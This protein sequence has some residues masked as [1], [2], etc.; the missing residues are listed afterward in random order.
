[1]LGKF[2]KFSG[3][4]YNGF[5]IEKIQGAIFSLTGKQVRIL[6]GPATVI[7]EF[8]KKHHSQKSILRRMMTKPL[9]K[10][11]EDVKKR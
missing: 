9:G 6:Y 4:G 1:M 5:Q 11:R 2:V 8:L 7:G 3:L 10:S